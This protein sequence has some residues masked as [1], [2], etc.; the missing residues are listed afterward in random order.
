MP[1]QPY[2]SPKDTKEPTWESIGFQKGVMCSTVVYVGKGVEL[3]LENK[4]K[5][6]LLCPVC[7]GILEAILPYILMVL[8]GISAI[9]VF[10]WYKMSRWA[11]KSRN[12]P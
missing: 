7:G 8:S 2:K 5:K 9:F 6:M 12:T 11:K 1:K 10:V 3:K 4:E